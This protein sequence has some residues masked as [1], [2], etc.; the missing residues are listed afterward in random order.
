[1]SACLRP[2]EL[3]DGTRFVTRALEPTD[4]WAIE[5]VF[6]GLG[7]HSRYTRFGGAKPRLSDNELRYLTE[8]DHHDH[9]ALL[10][11]DEQSG[12]PVAVARFVRDP[13]DPTTAELALAVT[14]E[15]Q[16]RALGTR[17]SQLLAC[18]ARAERIERFRADVLQSNGRAIALVKRLGEVV[19]YAFAGGSLELVVEL[20]PS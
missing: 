20:A 11:I 2:I 14:D 17:L 6:A 1:M 18:R 19:R 16:G 8:V 3:P 13:A 15:W 12:R 9:E 7:E 5:E 4:R 10:A